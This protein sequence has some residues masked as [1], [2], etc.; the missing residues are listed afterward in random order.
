MKCSVII[1][2]YNGEKYIIQQLESIKNQT[3][4]PIEVIIADDVSSDETVE[5]IERYISDNNLN[6]AWK[7]IRNEKNKGYI[8]NFIDAMNAST[9]EILFPCDQDDIWEKDKVEKMVKVVLENDAEA[10]YCLDDY[11]GSEGEKIDNKIGYSNRIKTKKTVKLINLRERLKTGRS[12][13]LCLCFRRSILKD[14]S[15]I[16]NEYS[17][18]HDLPIG[19]VAA[20]HNNYYLL[21]EVLVHHRIHLS[22]ASSPDMDISSSINNQERQIKS[23][24]IKGEEFRVIDE[25][26]ASEI[27]DSERKK[28]HNAVLINERL[29]KALEKRNLFG[30]ITSSIFANSYF[31]KLLL[32][33]NMLYL[34]KAN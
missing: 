27:S 19:L 10:V 12:P 25:K 31:N 18:P 21:N 1:T 8:K 2:T 14:I 16:C 6:N 3:Y 4:S 5:I 23:R 17:L 30:F 28:I 11:I 29:I 24:R 34:I 9:G 20:V 33:R 7:L 26:Y 13:G 32:I 15:E 22:N